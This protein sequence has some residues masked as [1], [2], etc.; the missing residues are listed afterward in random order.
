MWG[1]FWAHCR[2]QGRV[3]QLCS[4]G[5]LRM[6]LP[7]TLK[8]LLPAQM[9]NLS[10]PLYDLCV[11]VCV[12]LCMHPIPAA[13]PAYC[14]RPSNMV[15]SSSHFWRVAYSACTSGSSYGLDGTI[16]KHS[17]DEGPQGPDVAQ[18]GSSKSIQGHERD[19]R[20]TS[21]TVLK[22]TWKGFWCGQ[23]ST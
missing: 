9:C 21:C 10:Q 6:H 15:W 20:C 4:E 18:Q 11:C 22:L 16:R 5:T 3:H 7:V 1:C 12:W 19:I 23:R 2:E 13:L 17:Q 14:M 8:N